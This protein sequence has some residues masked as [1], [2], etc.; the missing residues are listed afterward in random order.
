MTISQLD[1]VLLGGRGVTARLGSLEG[2]LRS[3]GARYS[4]VGTEQPNLTRPNLLVNSSFEFYN[5][6]ETAPQDWTV[7]GATLNTLAADAD[8]SST[9][10]LPAGASVRQL[11]AAGNMVVAGAFVLSL[12]ARAA[13]TG[14]RLA[15]TVTHTP[16]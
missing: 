7:S 5:R 12:V 14:S 1:L 8:G 6:N 4:T 15:L 3:T 16:G 11:A 2:A 9:M 10:S 13:S